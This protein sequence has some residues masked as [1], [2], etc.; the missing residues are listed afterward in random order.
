MRGRAK[1]DTHVPAFGNK[2]RE[3]VW[4]ETV[5]S[6]SETKGPGD[7]Q[8]VGGWTKHQKLLHGVGE[9]RDLDS[10][11]LDPQKLDAP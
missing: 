6:E 11:Q 7:V 3:Q 9:T 10:E 2:E 8:E 4:E 1:V 5:T